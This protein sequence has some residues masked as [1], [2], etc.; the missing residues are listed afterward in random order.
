[1][2]KRILTGLIALILIAALCSMLHFGFQGTSIILLTI[3]GII[4]GLWHAITGH[5]P[6]N[7]F[8]SSMFRIN[9]DDDPSNLPGHIVYP[10]LAFFILVAVLLVMTVARV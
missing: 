10:I 1:M 2:F 5:T 8:Y 9:E 6:Q 7:F 3:G 4:L